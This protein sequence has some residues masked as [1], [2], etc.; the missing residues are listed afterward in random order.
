M[1]EEDLNYLLESKTYVDLKKNDLSNLLRHV[2]NLKADINME[3]SWENLDKKLSFP[4]NR[5]K[6]IFKLNTVS[7]I[8]AACFVGLIISWTLY[9]SSLVENS[10]KVAEHKYLFLPDG[11][12]VFLNASSK[13]NY[14]KSR[15]LFNKRLE[16]DG[17]A[18]FKVAKGKRFEVNTK[19]GKI[20]VMGT[21][22]KVKNRSNFF[23][24]NCL[25]GQVAVIS[26]DKEI[27]LTSGMSS[28]IDFQNTGELRAPFKKNLSSSVSWIW[29]VYVFDNEPLSSVIEEMERQ[30]DIHFEIKTNINKKYTGKFNQQDLKETL[31]LVFKPL[32]IHYQKKEGNVFVLYN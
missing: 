15:W 7:W 12:V 9:N 21:V 30:F 19:Y 11:S 3:H 28:L 2:S 16:L 25:E 31:E 6:S 8:A 27:L 22:F 23:E 24:V 18:L 14:N 10:T 17:E 1:K 20:I 29:D 26:K 32:G 5:E 13:I 4:S